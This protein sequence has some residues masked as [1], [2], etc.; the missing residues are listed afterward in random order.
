MALEKA[1]PFDLLLKKAERAA[2]AGSPFIIV[3]KPQASVD[4]KFQHAGLVNA[5]LLQW[6]TNNKVAVLG[7][8]A[9]PVFFVGT[10]GD[11]TIYGGARFDQGTNPLFK[12]TKF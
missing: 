5:G 4:E 10:N 11:V 9:F 8:I 2:A 1:N 6:Q 7:A 3:G 12:R